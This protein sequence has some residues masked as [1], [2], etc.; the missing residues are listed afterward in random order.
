MLPGL[1]IPIFGRN[2]T[3]IDLIHQFRGLERMAL[4]FTPHAV[5]RYAV[6]VSVHQLEKQVLCFRVSGAPFTQELCDVPVFVRH[7]PA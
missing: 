2:Q 6:Q 7:V 4:P 1:P 3:E 5:V